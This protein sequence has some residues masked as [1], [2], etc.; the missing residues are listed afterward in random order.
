MHFEATYFQEFIDQLY[1][2]FSSRYVLMLVSE[3]F[4]PTF[5][6]RPEVDVLVIY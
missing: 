3:W 5:F 2:L 1:I 4:H 6:R